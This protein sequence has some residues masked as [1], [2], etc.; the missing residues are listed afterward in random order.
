MVYIAGFLKFWT[1]ALWVLGPNI[2]HF[3]LLVF[4]EAV[5]SLPWAKGVFLNDSMQ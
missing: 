2:C 3:D 4:E 5:H 1:L